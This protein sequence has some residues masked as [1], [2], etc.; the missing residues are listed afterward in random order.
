ML[1]EFPEALGFIFVDYI[2]SAAYGL[3]N[4]GSVLAKIES[5]V[6]GVELGNFI[7]PVEDDRNLSIREIHV[8]V[9]FWMVNPQ[10]VIIVDIV[11]LVLI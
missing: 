6:F 2:D 11:A 8:A 4:A 10:A 3:L 9:S 7:C 1:N 5:F